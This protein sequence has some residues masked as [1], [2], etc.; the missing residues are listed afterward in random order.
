[1]SSR[2][3]RCSAL[4]Q[5][6]KGCIL[7]GAAAGGRIQHRERSRGMESQLHAD[8]GFSA[9]PSTPVPAVTAPRPCDGATF[10]DRESSEVP[11]LSCHTQRL[12]DRAC[13]CSSFAAANELPCPGSHLMDSRG[14]GI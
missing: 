11:G 7:H 10:L 13:S 6:F 4:V 5:V 2:N 14:A 8:L 9:A 3:S 12:W 1:M